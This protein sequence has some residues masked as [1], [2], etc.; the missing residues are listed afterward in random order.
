[1]FIDE[2]WKKQKQALPETQADASQGV[3]SSSKQVYPI[4]AVVFFLLSLTAVYY[5]Y[6]KRADDNKTGQDMAA[7]QATSTNPS[8]PGYLGKNEDKA[9]GDF[10]PDN[11]HAEDLRFGSFY[12]APQ[13]FLGVKADPVMTPLNIKSD[14]ANYYDISRKVDIKSKIDDLNRD[15][16]AILDKQPDLDGDDFFSSY[17]KLFSA[18]VP[19]YLSS[20]FV[21]YY[22][23]NN[24]KAAYK[25]IEK[26]V[27]YENL[28]DINKKFYE[29]ALSRYRAHLSQVGVI[30]DPMLEGERLETA[31]WALSLYLLKPKDGQINEQE[32]FTDEKLFS[33]QEGQ[34][35]YFDVPA[36]IQRELE[37]EA[38]L[39]YSANE[40]VH[41]PIFLYDR[42]Y[43]VFKVP[44]EYKSNSKLNNYYLAKKWLNSVFPLY[45]RSDECPDCLLD[46]ND[47]MNN[48]SAAALISEDFKNNQD[49]KNRWAAIYKFISFFEGLRSDLTYLHV[50]K[51]FEEQFPSGY[52]QTAIFSNS[53][54]NRKA[55]LL[56]LAGRLANYSFLGIEGGRDRQDPKSKPLLGVRI[57]QDNYWPNDFI[58]SRL[59][60]TE[61]TLKSGSRKNQPFTACDPVNL[62]IFRCK[63]YSGDVLNLFSIAP[64]D[65]K[66]YLAG[67]NFNNYPSRVADL[68]TQLGK[69]DSD[70]WNMNVYWINFD[71]AKNY[72]SYSQ[73]LSQKLAISK[74]WVDKKIVNTVLGSWVNTSLGLD[75]WE[76]YQAGPKKSFEFEKSC[77]LRSYVEPNAY[78]YADL[79]ERNNILLKAVDVLRVG[80]KTNAVSIALNEMNKKIVDIRKIAEKELA[81]ENINDEDCELIKEITTGNKV[82][83]PGNK[84]MSWGTPLGYAQESID[85]VKL[86]AF[87]YSYKKDEKVM[88]VGP[89]FN[90]K[91]VK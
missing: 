8:F 7:N 31:Y 47:W 85:G 77:D 33:Y 19:I 53:N 16:F 4:V 46:Y 35:Y 12:N 23:Q 13:K 44:A 83:V 17:Q 34:Q 70:T 67:T 51:A 68:E 27:F 20:D 48:F 49:L 87:I 65:S 30:N 36:E 71:L 42:D 74:N 90:F 59:T 72:I 1:M 86:M 73:D 40:V 52:S 29:I 10:L 88:A 15:G 24:L 62:P 80:K 82:S 84:K 28:W 54:E 39:I 64:V 69:F 3:F 66:E 18:E 45:Y 21:W 25:E 78:F 89:I 56:S 91:E 32:N 60:G 26:S 61:L 79:I 22:Y 58:L 6:S 43:S 37:K 5:F 41:S 57:L 38:K 2:E 14:V 75:T 55:D 76:K 50:V 11:L 81:G 9:E 63:A